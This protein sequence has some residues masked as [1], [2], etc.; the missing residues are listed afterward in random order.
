M[1]T[2]FKFQ[3]RDATGKTVKGSVSA[4]TQAEVLS[5]LRRRNLTPV[6]V[7]KTGGFSA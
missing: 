5:D 2:K 3:A 7:K 6:E 1:A 4:E